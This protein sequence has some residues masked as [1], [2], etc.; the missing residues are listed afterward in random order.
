M[1]TLN[2]IIDD[3][4]VEGHQ[5]HPGRRMT[6]EEFVAWCNEKTKAEWVDG[7]IIIMSPVNDSHWRLNIWL[8]RLLGEFVEHYELGEL[9]GPQ[10]QI[11]LTWPKQRREPDLLFIA[12]ERKSII[13]RN[14]I[15]GAPDLIIEIV[16]PD[17]ITRDWR[18]KYY[19]Y[20]ASRVR[21]YWVIDPMSERFDAYELRDSKY[22]LIRKEKDVIRSGVLPGFFLKPEWLWQD[23]LPKAAQILKEIGVA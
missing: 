23:P 13:H 6:E 19:A 8:T 4:D 11:R 7:E 9:C 18:D 14:H 12:K 15:E 1:T 22:V 10:T 5:P 16:S 20:E 17:S 3:E 21:E 2:D